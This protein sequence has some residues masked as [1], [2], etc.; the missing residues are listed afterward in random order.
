MYIHFF[1]IIFL[2]VFS[3]FFFLI[4]GKSIQAE[5]ISLLTKFETR[6]E[7][8]M[9]IDRIWIEFITIQNSDKFDPASIEFNTIN[10]IVMN[11]I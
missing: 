9:E 5:L 8:P 2:N 1:K 3:F 10:G 4:I 11:S 6:C 7:K